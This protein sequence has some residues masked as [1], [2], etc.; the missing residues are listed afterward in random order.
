MALLTVSKNKKQSGSFSLTAEAAA[1]AAMQSKIYT[2]FLSFSLLT[3]AAT[4]ADTCYNT[5]HNSHTRTYAHTHARTQETHKNTF[6][7]ACDRD[8]FVITY[9]DVCKV[10][11][12]TDPNECEQT[13]KQASKQANEMII[14]L[15]VYTRAYARG[16]VYFAT[17]AKHTPYVTH[18]YACI[19]SNRWHTH[20]CVCVRSYILLQVN[21][22]HRMKITH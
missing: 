12:P 2:F 3:V 19:L 21:I 5:V 16:V 17:L 8:I 15:C 4:A 10:K 7:C 11:P 13:I 1:A 18:S 9:I 14:H 22:Q 20:A 6:G